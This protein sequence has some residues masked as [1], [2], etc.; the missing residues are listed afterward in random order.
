MCP[1]PRGLIT[2]Q[3]NELKFSLAHPDISRVDRDNWHER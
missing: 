1:V 3:L 2:N